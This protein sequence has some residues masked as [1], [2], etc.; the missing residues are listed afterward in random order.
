MGDLLIYTIAIL[1]TL[2]IPFLVIFY[3]CARKWS[4]HKLKALHRTANF[5][6]PVFILAVHVLL[7]VLFNRSFFPYII[8][9]LLFLLGLSMIAQYKL[10][11]EVQLFRALKGFWR[12]SFL[13]FILVYVGLSAYGLLSRVV[14]V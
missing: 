2:P 8:I 14:F 10:K 6:A 7:V 4:K 13:L 5:T 9:F 1:I 12:V 11:E 3:L